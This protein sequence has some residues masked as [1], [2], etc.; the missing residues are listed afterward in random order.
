L[1][2]LE[3]YCTLASARVVLVLANLDALKVDVEVLEEGRDVLRLKGEGQA[4]QTQSGIVHHRDFR[5]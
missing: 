4:S 3:E 5:V 2:A 1:L